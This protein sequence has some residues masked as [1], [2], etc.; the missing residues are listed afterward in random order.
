MWTLHIHR[1]IL[2]VGGAPVL[3]PP[4]HFPS[5][6]PTW[7]SGQDIQMDMS[8]ASIPQ[9]DETNESWYV[10]PQNSI[11]HYFIIREHNIYSFFKDCIYL[12]IF[13]QR[14]REEKQRDR[15]INVWLSLTHPLQ[16]KWSA[17]QACVQT[18]TQTSNPLLYRPC[19]I[20]WATPTRVQYTL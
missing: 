14:R 17:T 10:R 19:S 1:V 8:T 9:D 7:R 3:L 2:Y 18:E 15:N 13:R 16:G 12:F 6:L 4:D 20:H 5:I 11:S